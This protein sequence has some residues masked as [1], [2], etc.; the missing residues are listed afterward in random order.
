MSGRMGHCRGRAGACTWVCGCLSLGCPVP[1]G[2]PSQRASLQF[3]CTLKASEIGVWP[4]TQNSQNW[5][6]GCT[7]MCSSTAPNHKKQLV[8]SAG[9]AA[10]T[11]HQPANTFALVPADVV[12]SAILASAAVTSQ[13]VRPPYIGSAWQVQ[14]AQS[15]DLLKAGS[16]P[17]LSGLGKQ[18]S[19]GLTG[20]AASWLTLHHL[21][22]ALLEESDLP[23]CAG[24]PVP[25]D[26]VL[27]QCSAAAVRASCRLMVADAHRRPF[28][29][30]V[31]RPPEPDMFAPLLWSQAY[32]SRQALQPPDMPAPLHSI[33]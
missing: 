24:L 1:L 10:W 8:L 18:H 23:C 21:T 15:A 3:G 31:Q 11:C 20:M 14:S 27:I 2:A 19:Q 4:E 33:C 26:P 28:C 5:S 17:H 12:A 16:W 6:I 13:Q 30:A 22:F 32:S 9:I 25:R 7:A 29:T